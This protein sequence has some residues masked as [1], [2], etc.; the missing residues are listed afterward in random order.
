MIGREKERQN[1]KGTKE[2]DGLLGK[3]YSVDE[4]LEK[5]EK[6]RRGQTDAREKEMWR[7]KMNRGN[8][9]ASGKD[10]EWK[11]KKNKAMKHDYIGL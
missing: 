11:T 3:Q 4:W 1:G 5:K 9:T 2:E 10:K 7:K 6:D 8:Y